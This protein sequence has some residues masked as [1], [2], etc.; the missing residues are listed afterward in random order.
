M[1]D[2]SS[3]YDLDAAEAIK[4]ASKVV[5]VWSPWWWKYLHHVT[6]KFD[7]SY[8]RITGLSSMIFMVDPEFVATSSVMEVA[9]A[10]EYA[11]QQ[12]SRKLDTKGHSLKKRYPYASYQMVMLAMSLEI[13]ADMAKKFQAVAPRWDKLVEKYID[14]NFIASYGVQDPPELPEGSYLPEMF[15]FD[16]EQTAEGYLKL[17]IELE[18]QREEER[19]EEAEETQDTSDPG[20]EGEGCAE[21]KGQ[22]ENEGEETSGGDGGCAESEGQGGNEGQWEGHLEDPDNSN[23]LT[24]GDSNHQGQDEGDDNSGGDAQDSTQGNQQG[25]GGSQGPSQGS[26]GPSDG[27]GDDDGTNTHEGDSGG[28]QGDLRASSSDG[29]EVGGEGSLSSFDG[30]EDGNEED[31]PDSADLENST[32]PSNSAQ[33][34]SPSSSQGSQISP[35]SSNSAQPAS[36]NS[37]ETSQNQPDTSQPDTI[38]EGKISPLP[39]NSAQPSSSSPQD[40]IDQDLLDMLPDIQGDQTGLNSNNFSS[41]TDELTQKA[42]EVGKHQ[43]TMPQAHGDIADDEAATESEKREYKKELAQEVDDYLHGLGDYE[44][45]GVPAGGIGVSDGFSDWVRKV[46]R[47]PKMS[48]KKVL[49]AI[50]QTTTGKSM[51]SGMTDLSFAKRNPNQQENMPLMMGLITYPPTVNVII[52]ASPSMSLFKDKILGECISIVSHFFMN[53][54]EPIGLIVAD[55]SIKYYKKTSSVGPAIKKKIARTYHGG[56]MGS[57]QGDGFGETLKK[58][59]RGKAIHKGNRIPKADITIVVTDGGFDWPY[60]NNSRLPNSIGAVVVVCAVDFEVLHNNR[61]Y[62]L[63]KWVK[64][65]RNFVTVN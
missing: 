5:A 44:N 18:Q 56:S 17:L 6:Y 46:L 29:Q 33:P 43:L 24:H 48:W 32:L 36:V 7:T 47:R 25:Q 34:S 62:P 15:G 20:D 3:I 54:G 60:A 22:G 1:A 51:Q 57:G 16:Y 58:V 64:K 59:L 45:T 38:Q 53:Y 50:L 27:L 37:D 19:M 13:N 40:E 39:S 28:L 61:I 52:D 35:E 31:L 49:P 14:K 8:S 41:L 10:L 2:T 26:E 42:G 12:S 23:P 30:Y 11:L 21:S 9:V 65:K 63:P 55:N 4:R